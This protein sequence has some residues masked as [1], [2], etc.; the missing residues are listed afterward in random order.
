MEKRRR[1]HGLG[2]LAAGMLLGSVATTLATIGIAQEQEGLR[3]IRL[4]ALVPIA[5]KPSLD[6]LVLPQ[7]ASQ[8]RF[9]FELTG[10]ARGTVAKGVWIAEDVGT[11]VPPNFTID[12]A[13]L[14][15]DDG[16]RTGS[17]SLNRPAKGWPV[18]KYRIEVRV[19][20]RVLYTERFR[21]E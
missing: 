15:F 19:G 20:D 2:A 4:E 17:F 6:G 10:A 12:S 13:E 9:H 1:L 16:R 18:G 7:E 14:H 5:A 11:A 8:L 3:P 21:I